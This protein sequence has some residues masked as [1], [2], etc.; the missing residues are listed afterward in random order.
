MGVD[1]Y[2]FAERR[3]ANGDW[4]HVEPTDGSRLYDSGSRPWLFAV[5]AGVKNDEPRRGEPLTPIAP[6]RGL[7]ADVSSEVRAAADDWIPGEAYAHSWLGLHELMEFDWER[8]A[9]RRGVVHVPTFA[10]WDGASAPES[11]CVWVLASAQCDLDNDAMRALVAEARA[12]DY[13]LPAPPHSLPS[14]CPAGIPTDLHERIKTR[15][16]TVEW[17]ETYRTICQYFLDET[18]PR[19]RELGPPDDVRTVF[20]FAGY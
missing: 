13:P 17:R 7:P 4:S 9:I 16:T 18:I 2:L 3:G 19:L 10:A 11:S 6:P 14:E 1:I 12:N 5:L 20:F 8:G 15:F